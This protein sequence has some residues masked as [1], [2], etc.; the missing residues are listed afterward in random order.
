MRDNHEESQKRLQHILE[1]INKI[2]RHIKNKVKYLFV[3]MK[4]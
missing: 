3:K 2:D 1:A 4:Y